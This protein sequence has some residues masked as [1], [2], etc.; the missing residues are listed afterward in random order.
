MELKIAREYP[1]PAHAY[2]LSIQSD[3]NLGMIC[4]NT[5]KSDESAC[6]SSCT[7]DICIITCSQKLA[8]CI[9]ACPCFEKCQHGCQNCNNPICPCVDVENNPNYIACEEQV[10]A[11]FAQCAA[12]CEPGAYSCT[13][14]CNRKYDEDVAKCPC[15]DSRFI[16]LYTL[17]TLWHFYCRVG[18]GTR[19]LIK[20][21]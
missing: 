17:L 14:L 9:N 3:R 21:I 20:L 7:D 8:T 6:S 10:R 16:A 19:T 1:N 11:Q 18:P 15:Q 13:V 12:A 5:C 4:Q 2:T